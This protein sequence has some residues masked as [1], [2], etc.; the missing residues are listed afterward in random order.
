M[1]KLILLFSVLIGLHTPI[2][3][4]EIRLV[5]ASETTTLTGEGYV[6]FDAYIYNDSEKRVVVPAPEAGFLI[7]WKLQDVDKVR[8][9]REGSDASVVTDSLQQH[10][11]DPRATVRIRLGERFVTESGDLLQFHVVVNL[12][13]ESGKLREIRSNSLMMFR[14]K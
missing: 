11:L 13:S 12:G 1:R 4:G 2:C 5:I 10:V 3:T 7:E 8:P 14:P 9:A 6:K